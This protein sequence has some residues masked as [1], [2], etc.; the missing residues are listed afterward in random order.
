MLSFIIIST[1]TVSYLGYR[2]LKN[3]Q[4]SES[5]EIIIPVENIELFSYYL[6]ND[7]DEIYNAIF[8][9]I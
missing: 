6:Y 8:L 4:E 1:L 5:R 7:V 3:K 2:Y 9:D